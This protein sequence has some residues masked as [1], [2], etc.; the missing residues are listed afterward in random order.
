LARSELPPANLEIEV[1][2][3]TMMK[4]PEAMIRS[5]SALKRLGVGLALDDFGTGYSSLVYLQRFPFDKLKIDRAFIV[6]V[7][8]SANHAT[9]THTISTM[10]KNLD[11]GVIAEGVETGDQLAFLK[12]C[13]CKEAQGY[14]FS[15]PVTVGQFTELLPKYNQMTPCLH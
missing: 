15:R 5:L 4:D 8:T 6:D 3:S 12:Q 13:G 9:M 14:L 7:N 11:M 2:E 1:T 10:A